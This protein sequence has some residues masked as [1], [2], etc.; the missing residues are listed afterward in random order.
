VS[1]KLVNAGLIVVAE[2]PEFFS[3]LVKND[4]MKYRKLVR[5]IGFTPQ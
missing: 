3:N 4:F 5:D 1:E 2:S